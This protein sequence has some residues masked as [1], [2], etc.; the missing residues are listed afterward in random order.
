MSYIQVKEISKSYSDIHA[1][2]GLSMEIPAGTLFGILGPNGAGKSTLIKILATLIEPD[3]GEISINNINL[4]KNSRQI[5]ELIGYVAQDVALDKI[6]TGRELLDF[7]SDLYHINKNKKIERIETLINQLEMN[8]WIDRKCGTYS[9][10]MKRRIDL[11]AGLLHLPKVLI[12]DEPTVGLDIESRNIIW[13]LLKD[14]RNDGMTVLLS[15]HY[16]DE[17]DKLAD[18]LIIIDHGRVIAQGTPAQLKNKLG[19]DRITLKVR[20]F[21]NQ[22]EAEKIC[23]ILSL[24]DGITQ[25][26]INKAQGYSI[27]FVADKEKDLLPK[28]K[29]ELAFSKFE[30][31]SLAQSQPS[32]D[33][34]YL[35][36]TGKTLLDA[37][38]SMAGKRDLKKESKQSMR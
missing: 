8:D 22:E 11:A 15:S 38:I 27:N 37:E 25:I 26:I 29:V 13:Q 18:R 14:L 21:S 28:L 17:I 2:K 24:I 16:L 12:L 34:V 6:L 1:L 33:D 3:S 30:I 4:I 35:Q 9:G 19:G 32:L 20:E 7:Q 31:F 5:R 10:G 36:A 23:E